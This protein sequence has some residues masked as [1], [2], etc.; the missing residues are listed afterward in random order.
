MTVFH[1]PLLLNV[2]ASTVDG[3]VAASD[4]YGDRVIVGVVARDFTDPAD[5]AAHIQALQARGVNVSAGLG[6]GAAD[7]WERALEMAVLARP[8]HLNQVFPAAALSQRALRLAGAPTVVNAL[9]RPTGTAGTVTVATG[10]VSERAGEG[11]LPV[12][13]ALDML[14][15]TGVRSVKLFPVEGA[16]RL[17]E[18]RAV[19]AAV[20]ERDMALEPTGGITP[21]NLSDVL[22]V[23]LD[24]G[25]TR[26]MPHLYGSVKDP[27]TGDLCPDRLAA[28]MTVIDR[29][30]GRMGP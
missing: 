29:F 15:E 4:R 17:A 23:C 24:A 28:A 8:F 10:P 26:L 22:T 7:Q 9:V 5:G 27:A 3:A 11:R 16:A 25:A 6:D 19:A 1:R 2:Q 18:L 20:A 12:G 30:A 14:A 13:A 21:G